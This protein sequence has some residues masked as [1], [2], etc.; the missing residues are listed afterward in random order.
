MTSIT[1]L[2]GR[3]AFITGASGAL[4]SAAVR[5]FSEAGAT[6]CSCDLIGD[7]EIR[8]DVTD[9]EQAAATVERAVRDYGKID[10][11]LNIVII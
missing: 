2:E 4:G 5:V 6:I 9:P 8:A 3:V 7:V 10:I 11:L 1:G